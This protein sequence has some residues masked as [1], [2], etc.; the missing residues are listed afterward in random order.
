MTVPRLFPNRNG[1]ITAISPRF[2]VPGRVAPAMVGDFPRAATELR[3]RTPACSIITVVVP[4]K[5]CTYPACEAFSFER[6]IS[7]L[8]T[9]FI[10]AEPEAVDREVADALRRVAGQLGLNRVLVAQRSGDHTLRF[11]HQWSSEGSIPFPSVVPER[12]LPWLVRHVSGGGEP[13]LIS[14]T[15]DLPA[16]AS[17]LRAL[18]EASGV[19]SAAVFPLVVA[20]EVVGALAVGC[21]ARRVWDDDLVSRL[22]LVSEVIGGAVARRDKDLALRDVLRQNEGLRAE[23]EA[24]N[25]V[26]KAEL[27]HVHDFEDIV[28]TSASL[29]AVLQLADQVAHTDATVLLTGET[30]TGKERVAHAIHRRSARSGR[31]LVVV[32]CAALPPTLIESELFGHEKG[33]FTGA[34]QAKAGRFELADGGTILL[35]EIGEVPLEMQPKL[36]RVLQD[37]TFERLGSTRSRQVDVRVIAATNRFMLREVQEGRFRADL[38]YRLS[39]FPIEVPPLRERREDIP[40]L[41]WFFVQDSARRFGRTIASIPKTSMDSLVAYDWPGNVR[42]LQNVV[43]RAVIVSTGP[44]LIVDERL[45]VPSVNPGL[46][47]SAPVGSRTLRE[48]L[49]ETEREHL[50]EILRSC[51]FII[52]GPGRAAEKLGLPPST[53]RDRMRKLGL[54]RP[55]RA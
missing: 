7:S 24:E 26:L 37:G 11:T 8:S 27:T 47:V 14:W 9:A 18:L 25:R 53:V 46:T 32:N 55:D 49:E 30:G 51:G 44:S 28:G 19:G 33:A 31:P 45:G 41:V 29:R 3:G 5:A 42:E 2:R 1:W 20:R 21:V 43:E 38:Y 23:L 50:L 6:L 34:T 15:S 10:S 54:Q 40:L 39:V 4:D 12:D 16:V 36:L 48:R 22:R 35:D 52:E 13:L 17:R